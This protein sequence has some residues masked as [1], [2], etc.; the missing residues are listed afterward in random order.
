[1]C[2]HKEPRKES[3][4]L[5]RFKGRLIVSSFLHHVWQRGCLSSSASGSGLNS[6]VSEATMMSSLLKTTVG[7]DN[8]DLFIQS[9]IIF[10]AHIS[11]ISSNTNVSYALEGVPHLPLSFALLKRKHTSIRFLPL[12]HI[13]FRFIQKVLLYQST[14][15]RAK[16]I[17]FFYWGIGILFN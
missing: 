1:M 15:K 17:T 6:E 3:Q 11:C 16:M 8:E 14:F 2:S 4:S 5:P 7:W 10:M 13:I 12:K 9:I